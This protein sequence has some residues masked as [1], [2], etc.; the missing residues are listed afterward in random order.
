MSSP[1]RVASKCPPRSWP[2]SSPCS[3]E[4]GL[5]RSVHR[6]DARRRLGPHKVGARSPTRTVIHHGL[7]D[8]NVV[9]E[10]GRSV[11][12]GIDVKTAYASRG[13]RTARSQDRKSTRLNSSHVSISYAV[14]CLNKKKRKRVDL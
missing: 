5:R 10:S 1:R 9:D 13:S 4:P 6:A 2:R 12:G 8:A 7:H 14:F 11:A 3:V